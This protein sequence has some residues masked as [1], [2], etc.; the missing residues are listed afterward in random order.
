VSPVAPEF[1]QATTARNAREAAMRKWAVSMVAVGWA[2]F[3][4]VG[5]AG[6]IAP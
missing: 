4:I 2:P 3:V 1:A 6:S 5:K